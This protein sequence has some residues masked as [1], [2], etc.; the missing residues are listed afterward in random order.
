MII[1]ILILQAYCD[2][3]LPAYTSDIVNVG[4][5]QGGI[6]EKIPDQIAKEDMEELE[7]FFTPAEQKIVKKAYK[8]DDKTY[9]KEAYVL[10]QDSLNEE[11]REVLEKSMRNSMILVSMLKEKQPDLLIGTIPQSQRMEMLSQ[12]QNKVTELPEM[13]EEQASVLYVRSIY[14]NLGIDMDQLQIH[15]IL[16]TGIKIHLH[17]YLEL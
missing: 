7:L 4:I 1:V 16:L 14:Q 15:Y 5:Q 17:F 8:K 10:N 2:L 6:D 3:S 13:M 11:K 12:M 9:K